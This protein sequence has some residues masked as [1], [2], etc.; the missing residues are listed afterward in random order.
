M[1]FVVAV[2]DYRFHAMIDSKRVGYYKQAK[3]QYFLINQTGISKTKSKSIHI[4]TTRDE[5]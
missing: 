4:L 1:M 5:D 3:H 2:Y